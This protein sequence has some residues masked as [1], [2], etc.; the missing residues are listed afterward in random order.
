[1]CPLS[2]LF[3]EHQI[4]LLT[5]CSGV[6]VFVKSISGV[7]GGGVNGKNLC[8]EVATGEKVSSATLNS[9]KRLVE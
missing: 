8:E 2:G 1:M 6:G 9:L 5:I 3:F 4:F 7:D